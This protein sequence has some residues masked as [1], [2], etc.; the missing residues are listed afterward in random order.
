MTLHVNGEEEGGSPTGAALVGSAANLTPRQRQW[1]GLADELGRSGFA[2]RAARYDADARFP[3]ENFDDLREAG[4]L[5]LCIPEAHG[6]QGADLYSYALVSATIGR[7]CGATALTYNMHVCATLWPGALTDALDLGADQRAEHERHRGLHYARIV[8]DGAVYAQSFSEGTAAATGRTPF[9]T[10]ARRVEGGWILNGRKVFTSLS[11]AADFYG[12]LC[13][14]RRGSEPATLRDALFVA[15]PRDAPGL[16]VVGDWDP[17]GMRATVSRT[18]VLKDVFAPDSAQMMPRGVYYQAASRWPHMFMTLAPTYLGIATAA[19]DFTIRYLRGEVE[20]MEPTPKRRMHP[21]KQM[22][23]AQM[24]LQLEQTR[25]LFLQAF[26]EAVIDPPKDARLRALAAHYT[27]MENANSICGLAIRTCGGH[28]MLQSLPL[29]RLYRDSRCGSLMLPWTAELCLDM[30][31][32]EAL[33]E[34]GEAD[35]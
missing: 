17:L 35:E 30:I 26:G 9:G 8:D 31:G 19:Y 23:V 14:E 5:A 28:S 11:G 16:S 25:A 1:I 24:H 6:G 18:L 32:R 4:L 20:G 27:V 29:E 33:Y 12:L 21:T 15:L 3:Y 2:A 13:S 22:A 7:Y 34:T 10:T